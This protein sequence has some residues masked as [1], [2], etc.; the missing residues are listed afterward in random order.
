ML[1]KTYILHMM[2]AT[3]TTYHWNDKLKQKF[4]YPEWQQLFP[5]TQAIHRNTHMYSTSLVFG[6]HLV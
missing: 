5:H 2:L 1:C 3:I 4:I 6:R